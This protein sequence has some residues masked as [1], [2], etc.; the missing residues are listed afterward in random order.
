[1]S[2]G[3]FIFR[4]LG[5]LAVILAEVLVTLGLS[6]L[7]EIFFPGLKNVKVLIVVVILTLIALITV[8][9]TEAPRDDYHVVYPETLSDRLLYR[10]NRFFGAPYVVC[11]DMSEGGAYYLMDYDGNII[12]KGDLYEGNDTPIYTAR[13]IFG[14]VGHYAMDLETGRLIVNAVNL[15]GCR[16]SSTR[17]KSRNLYKDGSGR[18]VDGY[19]DVTLTVCGTPQRYCL[20]RNHML[21]TDAYRTMVSEDGRSLMGTAYY[22]RDGL[23]YTGWIRLSGTGTRR[24]LSYQTTLQE[25]GRDVPYLVMQLQNIP[26][27]PDPDDAEKHIPG[28]WYLFDERGELVKKKG[29]CKK[30]GAVFVLDEHWM[31]ES[32]DDMTP[33]EYLASQKA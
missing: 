4:Q 26:G 19:Q 15:N 33:E 30:Y 27:A 29:K 1:M 8:K 28:G 24:V 32:V 3:I 20:D 18:W 9:V 5:F 14:P 6:R 31:V 25:G 16:R 21:V 17:D 11:T 10:F 7:L 23:P 13:T 12:R 2:T 22:S